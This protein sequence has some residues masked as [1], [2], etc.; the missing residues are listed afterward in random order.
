MKKNWDRW[1]HDE[2]IAFL[3]SLGRSAFAHCCSILIGCPHRSTDEALNGSGILVRVE[4]RHYVITAN[5]VVDG[6]KKKIDGGSPAH[7]Q[8]GQLI[9]DPQ[10]RAVHSDHERDLAIFLLE[11]DEYS[12]VAERPLLLDYW[13]PPPPPKDSCVFING[14]AA[15]N[16][17]NGDA[18]DIKVTSLHFIA[19]VLEQSDK[20][21]WARIDR[22]GVPTPRAALMPPQ[23]A[24]LG[25]LSGGP[26]MLFGGHGFPLVGI[27]SEG[28]HLIDALRISTLNDVPLP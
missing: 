3:E 8:I 18:G 4:N 10:T 11:G 28:S 27:V 2:R 25:G 16:R 22:D 6:L 7:M 1:S 13:P 9:L 23:G 20:Y 12:Q 19:W 26:V 5:H 21:F 24:S 15:Q 17:T 14:F